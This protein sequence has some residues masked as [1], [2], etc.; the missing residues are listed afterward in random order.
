[1]TTRRNR[2]RR[3]WTVPTNPNERVRPGDRVRLVG[4]LPRA[5]RHLTGLVAWVVAANPVLLTVAVTGDRFRHEVPADAVLPAD[6][7]KGV[8]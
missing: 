6:R 3:K 5:T 1:M 7:S 8:V 2:L 4:P